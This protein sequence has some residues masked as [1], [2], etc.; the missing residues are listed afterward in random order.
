MTEETGENFDHEYQRNTYLEHVSA[1]VL[2]AGL[3]LEIVN[4][5]VWFEGPKTIA[6]IIAVLLIGLGVAGEVWFAN[7][8]RLAGDKQ[9]ALY[10][11]RVAEANLKAQEAVLDLAKFRSPRSLSGEQV[12]HIK[13]K[14]KRKGPLL[15]YVG[16][17]PPSDEGGRLASLI[18]IAL[19]TADCV[20]QD[21]MRGSACLDAMGRSGHLYPRG[22]RIYYLPGQPSTMPHEWE[23]TRYREAVEA[24]HWPADFAEQL[25]IALNDEGI[26]AQVELDSRKVNWDGPGVITVVVGDK[27]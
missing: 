18:K 27:P 7:R 25:S 8:A 24:S 11:A 10:R 19:S 21:G 6:E 5:A 12:N 13:G 1:L 4:A 14:L 15:V 20:P 9:L 23:K 16:A 3:A 22:V 17:V 2:L 26:F